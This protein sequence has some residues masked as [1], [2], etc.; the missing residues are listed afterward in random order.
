MDPRSVAVLQHSQCSQGRQGRNFQLAVDARTKILFW[1]RSVKSDLFC[2]W[3]KLELIIIRCGCMLCRRRLQRFSFHAKQADKQMQERWRPS[4]CGSN[5][6]RQ[7]SLASCKRLQAL[8]TV[9]CWELGVGSE[10][11]H[12][13]PAF[14]PSQKCLRR[15][16][17]P[18]D[19][20]LNFNLLASKLGSI[21]WC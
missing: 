2:K 12:S 16:W 20:Y 8:M 11:A 10:G 9:M 3:L 19:L 4:N 15:F 18:N 5:C 6:G 7:E 14:E 17:I 13:F 21:N 1:G